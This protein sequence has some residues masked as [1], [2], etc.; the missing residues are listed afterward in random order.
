M[1]MKT[2]VVTPAK[3]GGPQWIPAFAGMTGMGRKSGG[4]SADGPH[5]K[6]PAIQSYLFGGAG[7]AGALGRSVG[8]ALTMRTFDLNC[9]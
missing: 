3:A 2:I 9:L 8:V 5:S 4:P 7:I 6:A 1:E